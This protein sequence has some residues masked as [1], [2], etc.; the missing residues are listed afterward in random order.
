M[1]RFIALVLAAVA[2]VAAW[3]LLG[4]GEAPAVV[5]Q[6]GDTLGKLAK[7]H[8]TTVAQLRDWNDLDGDLIHVGDSLRVGEVAAWAVPDW[9]WSKQPAVEEVTPSASEPPPPVSTRTPGP[10]PGPTD[11]EPTRPPLRRPAA[12]PCLDATTMGDGDASMGR[13]VGLDPDAVGAVVRGFQSRTLRC[14]AEHPAAGGTIELEIAVGC[15][16]RVLRVDVLDDG[17]GVEGYA[18]CVADVMTYAAFPAH[19][20][21]EVVVQV[22]LIFT[23]APSD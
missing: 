7:E 3:I 5:V 6:P 22:P 20:R 2:G 11:E 18:A 14:A 23:A 21:D 12:K 4:S 8:G 17:V 10:L 19:A 16:G 15:D 13:S 1:K 9:P